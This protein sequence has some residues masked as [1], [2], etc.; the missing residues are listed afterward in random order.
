LELNLHKLGIHNLYSLSDPGVSKNSGK[1]GRY[2]EC[3]AVK[4]MLKR[5]LI[6]RGEGK[7]I[8]RGPA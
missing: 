7:R 2:V 6:G 3:M 8:F 1:W 4:V 5:F